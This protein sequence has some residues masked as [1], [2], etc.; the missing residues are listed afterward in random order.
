MK[1]RKSSVWLTILGL[2]TLLA[3]SFLSAQ[4]PASVVPSLVNFSGVLT[5]TSGKPLTR[6]VGVTFSLYK[7]QQGDAPLWV[8]RRRMSS[9]TRAGT[10][11]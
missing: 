3:T 6:T 2:A 4:Q 7:D 10:T 1:R 9:P 5:D 8:K 11:P